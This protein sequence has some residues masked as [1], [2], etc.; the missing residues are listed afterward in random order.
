MFNLRGV[1]FTNINIRALAICL[2]PGSLRNAGRLFSSIAALCAFGSPAAHGQI[3][4]P[5]FRSVNDQNLNIL[6][7]TDVNLLSPT[8]DISDPIISMNAV[9]APIEYKRYLPKIGRWM[10]NT[11]YWIDSSDLAN[12]PVILGDETHVFSGA[13]PYTTINGVNYNG[14]GQGNALT[15]FV[16]NNTPFWRYIGSNGVSAVFDATTK[17]PS[18]I[19]FPSGLKRTYYYKAGTTGYSGPDVRIQS[20][21]QNDGTQLKFTY[22]TNDPSSVAAWHQVTSVSIINQAYASCDP[23]ADACAFTSSEWPTATFSGPLAGMAPA[24]QTAIETT[25]TSTGYGKSYKRDMYGRVIGIS[26]SHTYSE[27]LSYSYIGS[28]YRVSQVTNGRSDVRSYNVTHDPTF[29]NFTETIPSSYLGTSESYYFNIVTGDGMPWKIVDRNGQ[30]TL[31]EWSRHYPTKVT[32]PEGNYETFTYND[33]FNI[34]SK[35]SFPKTGSSLSAITQYASYDTNCININTCNSPNSYTDGKGNVTDW[36]YTSYGKK[37]SERRP[38]PTAGG[39][40]PLTL[41]TYTQKAAYV[42]VGGMLASTGEPIWM[43][44]TETQC[45]TVPGSNSVTCDP[46]ANQTVTTYLYGADGTAD[47]LLIRGKTVASGGV[48]LRTCYEYDRWRH[49]VSETSPNANLQVCS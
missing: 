31:Y 32:H 48:T 16:V 18:I 27:D 12:I 13:N 20:M 7:A 43:V 42:L 23:M 35:T 45:Q 22:Q 36:T 46:S 47:N 10:D 41:Y 26:N 24:G 30:P 38:A 44:D 15:T 19:E 1:N 3:A 49:K 2:H 21:I 4:A 39:A 28:T 17:V 40:R 9:D 11:L 6:T 5:E 37:A 14:D 25:T 33:R 34:T 8:I 29:A